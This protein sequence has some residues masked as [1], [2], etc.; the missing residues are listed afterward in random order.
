[1]AFNTAIVLAGG[2][3]SRMNSSI[4]K[5]YILIEDK[6]VLYYSLQTFNCS[7]IIDEIILV[8]REE[9]VD[10]CQKE[11]VEKYGFNKVKKII[12][13]GAER[14]LSVYNGLKAANLYGYVFIHDGARAC[15]TT[16][17]IERLHR[18]VVKYKAVVAAVPSKDTVKFADE[19]QNVQLTPDRNRVWI[20]QTPQ[21][22]ETQRII[23]AYDR[24]F[25]R[26]IGKMITDDAMIMEEYGDV[27]VHLEKSDYSNIKIT[28]PEDIMVAKMYLKNNN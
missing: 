21:V 26:N 5:Q 3:G 19:S 10:Y 20:V 4:P 23:A 12:A 6:P 24:M 18:S 15:I 25:T 8:T 17:L 22:F 14:Y 16:S 27:P 1:M 13:G 7:K 2:N 9:D 11:I 28:T